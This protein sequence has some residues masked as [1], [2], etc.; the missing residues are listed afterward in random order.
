MGL[1]FIKEPLA[2]VLGLK[3]ALLVADLA[4]FRR[5]HGHFVGVDLLFIIVDNRLH[6]LLVIFATVVAVWIVA[7]DIHDAWAL[8]EFPT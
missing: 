4:M 8:T 5:Q 7:L 3:R 2:F 6:G 1:V